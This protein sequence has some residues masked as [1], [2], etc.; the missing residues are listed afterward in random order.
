MK[1]GFGLLTQKQ[2][3]KLIITGVHPSATLREIF[4]QWPV[5][6]QLLESDV[7]LERRSQTT[8]GNAQQT[9]PLVEALGCKEIIL[10]TSTLHMHRALKTFKAIFPRDFVIHPRAILAGSLDPDIWD[11]INETIKTVFYGIWVY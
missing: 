1:E 8:Y 3:R 10:I 5:Y 9:L 11:A 6:G 2:V 4:P 7:I